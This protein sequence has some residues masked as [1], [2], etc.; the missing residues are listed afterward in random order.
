MEDNVEL[1]TRYL[2]LLVKVRCRTGEGG[3]VMNVV[4]SRDE[5]RRNREIA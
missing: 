4:G 1:K 3:R 5:V 2:R